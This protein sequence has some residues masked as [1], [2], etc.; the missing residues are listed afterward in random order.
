MARAP[1]NVAVEPG[2]TSLS[3]ACAAQFDYVMEPHPIVFQW[4]HGVASRLGT[5]STS[6]VDWAGLHHLF[7]RRMVI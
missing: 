3:S 6:K 5:E 1:V 4:F 2:R 7:S